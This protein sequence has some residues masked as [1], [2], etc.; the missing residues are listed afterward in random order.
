M[1]GPRSILL[2]DGDGHYRRDAVRLDRES[3]RTA[4]PGGHAL[5]PIAREMAVEETRR[6]FF[7]RSAQGIGALALA[8]LLPREGRG[9]EAIKSP[10]KSVADIGVWPQLQRVQRS[11]ERVVRGGQGTGDVRIP[12]ETHKADEV[13]GAAGQAM[14]IVALDENAHSVARGVDARNRLVVQH[15]IDVTHAE[16][17]IN[18]ELNGDSFGVHGRLAIRRLRACECDDEQDECDGA[19]MSE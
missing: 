16:A 5:D 6:R 13:V 9:A 11:Q 14:P 18:D 2:P 4:Q 1:T 8:S 10:C 15:V 3:H 17:G 12:T 7:S 19:E